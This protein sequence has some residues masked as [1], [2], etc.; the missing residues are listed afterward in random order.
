MTG[1]W[2]RAKATDRPPTE[3]TDFDPVPTPAPEQMLTKEYPTLL[4]RDDDD[5]PEYQVVYEYRS[6]PSPVMDV[7]EAFLIVV[8]ACLGA[9]A[10]VIYAKAMLS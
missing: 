5:P 7:Y 3:V 1:R 8:L 4:D 9:A 10:V 6:S 2:Q